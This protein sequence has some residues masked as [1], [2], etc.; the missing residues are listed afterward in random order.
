MSK[1]FNKYFGTLATNLDKKIPKSKKK[2]SDYLKNGNLTSF[3]LRKP[4]NRK[5]NKP[6][7]YFS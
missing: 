5:G 2:F 6:Y 3:L 7:H 4:G 1:H